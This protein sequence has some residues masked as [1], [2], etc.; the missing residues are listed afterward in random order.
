MTKKNNIKLKHNKSC[1]DTANHSKIIYS[2]TNQFS[3]D[4]SMNNPLSNSVSGR[5]YTIRKSNESKETRENLNN[6]KRLNSQRVKTRKQHN[7]YNNSY[8]DIRIKAAVSKRKS[9]LQ[10]TKDG[11]F[12][13]E[14]S[15]A[16]EAAEALGL[17]KRAIYECCVGRSR[18][19]GGYIWKRKEN[20]K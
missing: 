15:H 4:D 10:Y 9:V 5:N 20:M 18:T 16:R 17:N 8:N 12:I 2:S 11:K 13:R 7:S 3:M 14:W 19:S 6:I 1:E